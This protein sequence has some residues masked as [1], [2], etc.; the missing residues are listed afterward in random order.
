M[1]LIACRIS[2][3][4]AWNLVRGIRCFCLL[5]AE[6][7]PNVDVPIPSS[8]VRGNSSIGSTNFTLCL[9]VYSY[10]DVRHLIPP[11]LEKLMC[12]D[13]GLSHP[14]APTEISSNISQG[15]TLFTAFR[16]HS[17]VIDRQQ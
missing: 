2:P 7:L 9:R 10:F 1:P 16:S 11:F 3:T 8:Y 4:D 14:P 12:M 17:N 13:T 15:K 5:L 6:S